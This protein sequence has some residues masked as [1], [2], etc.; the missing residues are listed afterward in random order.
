[1]IDFANHTEDD[2]LPKIRVQETVT[3]LFGDQ[4]QVRGPHDDFVF[5]APDRGVLE[6][7]ELFLK[8][9]GHSNSLLFVE[10]GFTHESAEKEVDV[11]HLVEELAK[12]K[13]RPEPLNPAV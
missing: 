5:L 1:M 3:D 12:Q 10:Y 2:T 13:M 6:G 11:T 4:K 9:G 8:Y 7:D